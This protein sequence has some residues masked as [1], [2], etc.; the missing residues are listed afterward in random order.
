M[1]IGTLR[2]LFRYG[3]YESKNLA[4]PLRK[5][6]GDTKLSDSLNS[7]VIPFYNLEGT[8]LD[9]TKERDE[10][11]D[12]PV[13]TKNN[14][15]DQGGY[16][17]WLKNI[18]YG[19]NRRP[20]PDVSMFDA[21]MAS[22][23]APTYFPSHHF[24]LKHDHH[25]DS[26]KYAGIDGSIFDNPP[27]SYHGAIK[28]HVP[29][30][31]KVIT[32]LL[33]TGHTLRSFK[34][35]DWN[36]FGGLGVVDPMNDLPLINILFH[37]T[38]TALVESYSQEMEDIFVFNK[39]IIDLGDHPARPTESIDDAS[40]KNLKKMQHFF[41]ETLEEN[42]GKFEE[43]CHVLVQNRDDRMKQHHEKPFWKKWIN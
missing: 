7:L 41:E 11:D 26:S 9:V 1:K 17:V 37:A 31:T 4:E 33:G 30:D 2:H 18:K 6:Y 10:T 14:F 19:I 34:G 16:A 43:L 38:E 15:V 28:Q 5:L 42:R 35:D 32:I 40:P 3:N 23:A 22:T 27:V 39:S 21:I 29:N 36:R 8:P 25:K 12:M 24:E 13:H 20:P